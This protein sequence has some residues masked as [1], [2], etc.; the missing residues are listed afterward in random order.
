MRYIERYE[1]N[2]LFPVNTSG[3][4]AE[5][6]VREAESTWLARFVIDPLRSGCLE[7]CQCYTCIQRAWDALVLKSE[8][9]VE[10]LNETYKNNTPS[11]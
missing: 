9:A 4:S 5:Q 3:R 6:I 11:N 7:G 8:Q 1:S 2:K 10:Y